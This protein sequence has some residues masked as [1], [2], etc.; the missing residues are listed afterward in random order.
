MEIVF[1]NKMEISVDGMSAGASFVDFYHHPH[2]MGNALFVKEGKLFNSV[3][4]V[5]GFGDY[6][7]SMAPVAFF[8]VSNHESVEFLS[9]KK[10]DGFGFIGSYKSLDEHYIIL[11]ELQLDVS[12]FIVQGT[13]KEV[14]GSPI[15]TLDF[16]LSNVVSNEDGYGGNMLIS[17][18]SQFVVPG[19]LLFLGFYVDS[20]Y[21][22]F[23]QFYV[24]RVDWD[25]STMVCKIEA[26]SLSGRHL[27]DRSIG[28]SV[29]FGPN[30]SLNQIVK[31]L[32]VEG[33]GFREDRVLVNLG[34]VS[35][36]YVGL[37]FSE[38]S[39]ILDALQQAMQFGPAYSI[40]ETLYGSIIVG[41]TLNDQS[42]RVHI[43]DNNVLSRNITLDDIDVYS[44]VCV[45]C[46]VKFIEVIPR[47]ERKLVEQTDPVSGQKELVEVGEWKEEE[48]ER[49][50]VERVY[51]PVLKNKFFS[52][53]SGK[54]LFVKVADNSPIPMLEMF[55]EHIAE[56]IE[57]VGREEKVKAIF[58]PWVEA[59]DEVFYDDESIGLVT[60]IS[61]SFGKSGVFSDFSIESGGSV[62]VLTLKEHL[63]MLSHHV[64]IVSKF[65]DKH[66]NSNKE[67]GV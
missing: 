51:K 24:D 32:I 29:V 21:F 31:S 64:D 63:K 4:N 12:D 10:V 11:F 20:I 67:K 54:T 14:K 45:Y 36:E 41:E 40:K 50:W 26:R 55:A 66:K 34:N 28:Q 37:E 47:Y 56:K 44:T 62:G 9:I 39:S 33:G 25:V 16:T 2:S 1:E 42:R 49:N 8:D 35:N 38:E 27:K 18:D 61:H 13:V 5:Y 19:M 43:N 60:E 46:D 3:Y 53:E 6:G 7:F 22:D 65:R 57:F 52:L 23:G 58:M 30:D 48:V 15:R 17:K 59:G